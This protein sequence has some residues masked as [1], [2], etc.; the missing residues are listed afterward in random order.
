ML[1]IF[2]PEIALQRTGVDAI[3]S[4]LKAAGVPQHVRMYL[5]IETS[6]HPKPRN[7]LVHARRRKW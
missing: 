2:V 5:E 1:D 6:S 7:H 3:I 4:E